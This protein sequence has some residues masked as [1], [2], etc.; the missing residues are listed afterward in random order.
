RGSASKSSGK[1]S[2]TVI[3]ADR[4]TTVATKKATRGGRSSVG[5]TKTAKRGSRIVSKSGSVVKQAEK[6]TRTNRGSTD[7]KKWGGSRSNSGKSLRKGSAFTR[8][9]GEK[10]QHRRRAG[11]KVLDESRP[12]VSRSRKAI[13]RRRKQLYSEDY[14]STQVYREVGDVVGH[15]NPHEHV[16]VDYH[17]RIC[18]R[19]IWPEYHF[20]LY[21]NWGPHWSFSYCWPYYH[22]RYMFVSLGGYWPIGCRYRRYYWYGYHPYYWYG[23]YPIA[24]EIGGDTYNYYTYNYYYDGYGAYDSGPVVDDAGVVDHT[25][26]ADVR[27]R[28]AQQEEGPYEET[29]ADRYFEDA[30]QAFENG[31]YERAAELFAETIKLAPDDMIVPFAYCQS[32]FANG[33]YTEAAEVLRLALAKVSPEKEGV[34]Y[35]RGLY[36]EEDVL[37]EQI[38]RL[39]ATAEMYGLDGDLQLLGGTAWSC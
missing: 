38:D 7:A 17:D 13:A 29:L 2:G 3:K 30:V 34:F 19:S 14:G 26:F 12:V 27:E 32:L 31:D 10:S 28:L 24:R 1:R 8:P 4:K 15:V 36:T 20:G 21:Y 23:Y 5:S 33:R 22:R 11:R 35:P 39:A 25:T 16:Y 37:Y 9:A 6:R 18:H